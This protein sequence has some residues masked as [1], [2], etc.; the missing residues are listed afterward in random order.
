MRGRR[1]LMLQRDLAETQF[2]RVLTNASR[3]AIILIGVVVLLATLQ[4]GAVI[5]APVFLAVVVGLMFGPLATSIEKRGVPPA[6]SAGVVVLLFV[7]LLSLGLLLFAAPLMEWVG[8]GP[9]IWAKF[10][11][12]L[13]DWRWVIEGLGGVQ[14]QLDTVFGTSDAVTIEVQDEGTVQSL[15]LMAPAMAAH[16]LIFLASLYFYLATREHFRVSVLSLCFSRRM[17]WRAAHIFTDVEAKVSKFLL[18]VTLINVGVGVAVALAMWATGMPSPLLWGAMAAVFNFVPYVGQAVMI[19]VLLAGGLATQPDTLHILLPVACYAAINFV[20][21][22]IIYPHF[23]GRTMTLNPFLIFLSLTFWLWVWGPLG[24]LVAVPSL[25]IVISL[26]SHILPDPPP[27]EEPL[28][29]AVRAAVIEESA[30]AVAEKREAERLAEAAEAQGD[31]GSVDGREGAELEAARLIR[32]H[33]RETPP[34][35]T[36][37]EGI[38][39]R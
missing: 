28:P 5:L 9:E 11:S 22:N 16:V 31:D 24:G 1:P 7:A 33:R 17:R 37:P 36:A 10:R 14:E 21:G 8:R 23:I 38:V 25:L 18:S 4:A 30:E 27:A 29:D 12:L 6:L 20:E 26:L 13:E 15:A 34:A 2:E 35:G 19:A 3:L 32:Q 39:P